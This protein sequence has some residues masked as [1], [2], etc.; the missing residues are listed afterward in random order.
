LKNSSFSIIPIGGVEEIGS[1]MTIVRTENEDVVIDCGL[2]FPYEE[3]FDINYLIPDFKFLDPKRV[4]SLILTHG[5][6]DHIGGIQHFINFFPD[7]TIYLTPF[8]LNLIQ[9]KLSES[10]TNFKYVIY[11][12]DSQLIFDTVNIF[13]IHVNHSIPETHGL[14]IRDKEL[15]WGALYISDFKVD[16]HSSHEPPIELEKIKLLLQVCK[17]TAYFLDSTNIVYDGKTSSENEL[18]L[19]LTQLI[20][21]SQKRIFLTLFASNVHRA[22]YIAQAALN[23]G[24]KIVL[25]G[26]SVR[27]YFEAGYNSKIIPLNP[28][29]FLEP[30]AVKDSNEKILVILSG[31]QG[32]FLSALRRFSFGED[33]N[34]KPTPDDLIIFSSKVIPGNEKKIYRIYNKLSEFGAE[35][36]SANDALIHSS[37]HPG[38]EDIKILIANF[39]PDFYFPIHGESYLLKKHFEFI[40]S[41]YDNIDCRLIYNFHEI[42]FESSIPK[43]IKQDKLDPVIIHGKSLEIEKSQISQRRKMATQGTVFISFI[44]QKQLLKISTIGLPLMV[45]NLLPKLEQ[46]LLHQ[47]NNDLQSREDKYFIDQIKISTRQFFNNYLGYK[48]VTEFHLL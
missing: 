1:N 18:N 38:K 41:H 2:L 33:S 34:L 48:P 30:Q 47:I 26:R 8:C 42:K 31:C 22:S 9:K 13:P 19:D 36:V 5:H 44:K 23:A 16:L 46:K 17:R 3:C 14:V 28:E 37:G 11:N 24:R 39:K 27:H 45:E 40:K 25:M 32:D 7:A 12:S 20:N 29:N 21:S 4:K 6:E 43:I 15:N 10:K 35:I